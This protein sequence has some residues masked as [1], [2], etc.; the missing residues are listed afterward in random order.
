MNKVIRLEIGVEGP[1]V[2]GD[3]VELDVELSNQ[4]YEQM[5]SA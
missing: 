5:L 4:E 3:S 2:P 1:G